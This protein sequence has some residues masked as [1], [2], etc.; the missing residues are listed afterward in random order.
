LFSED[1]DRIDVGLAFQSHTQL[2]DKKYA[3]NDKFLNFNIYD[4]YIRDYEASYGM[5]DA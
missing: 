3:Q 4:E 2:L 1:V 5:Y